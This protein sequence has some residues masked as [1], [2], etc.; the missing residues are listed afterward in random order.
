MWTGS[1]DV[2][3]GSGQDNIELPDIKH[4]D[5]LS[6]GDT[7]KGASIEKRTKDLESKSHRGPVYNTGRLIEHLI[8]HA[9]ASFHALTQLS[10]YSGIFF[11]ACSVMI[12]WK[13]LIFLF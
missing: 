3:V 13:L 8:T 6:V 7:W 1:C 11:G 9:T 4:Q 2:E 12:K 5:D 10:L